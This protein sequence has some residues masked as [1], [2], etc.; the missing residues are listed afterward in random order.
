MWNH[1]RREKKGTVPVYRSP[2]LHK[3]IIKPVGIP[4]IC[5][6]ETCSVIFA[7]QRSKLYVREDSLDTD[8]DRFPLLWRVSALVTP[9]PSAGP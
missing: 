9:P 3:D 2:P 4:H 7:S 1:A 8:G 6:V 5:Q